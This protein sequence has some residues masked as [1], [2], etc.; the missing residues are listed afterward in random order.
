[1][2]RTIIGDLISSSVITRHPANPILTARDVPY[3]ATLVFNPGVTKY[4]DRYVMVFRNDYGSA[5]E[6]RLDGTN[7]G[8]AFSESSA[9]VRPTLDSP[10]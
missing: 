9:M 10:S 3:P 8:L 5:E 7:L 2:E 1:M 6:Q 4:Q